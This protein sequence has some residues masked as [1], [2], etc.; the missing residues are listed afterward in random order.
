MYEAYSHKKRALMYRRGRNIA[1][2]NENVL[3]YNAAK[4]DE[5]AIECVF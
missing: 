1:N 2:C 3:F 4:R 5:D